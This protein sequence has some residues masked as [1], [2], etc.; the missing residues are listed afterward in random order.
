MLPLYPPPRYYPFIVMKR[1]EHLAI[2]VGE[3]RPSWRAPLSPL[4][5]LE[6]LKWDALS[7]RVVAE[8]SLRRG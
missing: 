2:I 5:T 4:L 1:R 6:A 3:G 8:G 7:Y